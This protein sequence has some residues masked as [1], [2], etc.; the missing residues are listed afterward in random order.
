MAKQKKLDIKPVEEK[1]K[2]REEISRLIDKWSSKSED[3]KRKD[4]L[5]FGKT[6]QS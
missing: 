3:Q 4:A 5:K 2:E 6:L 1:T